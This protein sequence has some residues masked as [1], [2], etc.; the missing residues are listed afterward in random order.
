[1]DI[2]SKSFNTE[3]EQYAQSRPRYPTDFYEYLRL[4]WF[5]QIRIL[6]K[7]LKLALNRYGI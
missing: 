2:N 3:S 6:L 1:M 7:Y 5:S 4:H